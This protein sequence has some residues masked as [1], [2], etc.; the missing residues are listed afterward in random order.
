VTLGQAVEGPRALYLRF[1]PSFRGS[2][3]RAAFLLLDP[4]PGTP[5]G[6]DVP[7]E[8]WRADGEWRPEQVTS[9]A[10]PGFALPVATAIGRSAPPSLVRVDVTEI[11]QFLAAHP[12]LDHGL[13]VRATAR[14]TLG[15]AFATGVAGGN[16]PRLD[17]YVD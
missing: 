7:L 12:E 9:R 13:V 17:V 14:G 16:A 2:K 15:I 11:V 10:Q 3:V 5:A 4:R 8:V 1:P 6:P